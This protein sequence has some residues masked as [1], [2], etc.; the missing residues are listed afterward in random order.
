MHTSDLD[1]KLGFYSE[2][3]N[4]AVRRRRLIRYINLSL[5]ALGLPSVTKAEDEQFA[6]IARNMLDNYRAKTRLLADY[7]CPVDARIEEFLNGH[8]ADLDLGE[9]LRLP[10]LALTVDPHGMARELSL[11]VDGD[12]FKSPMVESYRVVNGV[13]HNPRND[14]R[15]TKGTFHVVEGGL[16]IPSGK[17]AVPRDAFVKMFRSAMN[18]PDDLSLIPFTANAQRPARA[19]VGLY[20]QPVVVPEVPGSCTEKRLEVR[21]F[22]PGGLVS[23]LDF[24]ESIFG[25]AGDPFLEAND[26]ARDVEHWTGHTGCVIL[27]P[28]LGTLTKRGLGLPQITDATDRQRAD[29]MCWQREDELYNDGLPFKVTCRT[30]EGVIVTLIADNYFGYCKKEVKTQISYSANLYGVAEEEHAG[31]ALVFPSFNI[32]DHYVGKAKATKDR[33][34]AQVRELYSDWVD[35]Q[36][37]GH[38]IDRRYPD[39]IFIPEDARASVTQ[40]TI[41]WT[42]NGRAQS[43]P[44][45]PEK[46]YM[47]PSGYKLRLERHP[48]APSWRLIGTIAEGTFC[49]KPC[50]V[51]G[52]GKSEISKSLHD[53]MLYGPIFV[54]DIE[55]DR[56]LIQEIF[57]KDYSTRWQPDSPE[58]SVY[59]TRPSRPPLS[60]ERSVGSLIKLLTPSTDYTDEYNEWLASIPNY[61][62]ALVFIIKRFY[63]SEWGKTG[64][65]D[66][67]TVDTVNGFP[68]HELKFEERKLVGSYLR[69]GFHAANS[70]RTFKLRQ[71]FSPSTKIQTEDDITASVVLPVNRIE[72]LSPY[73]VPSNPV[74]VKFAHNCEYRLFQRPDEA[75]HRGF[76]RQSEFDIAQS[77]N[78]LSNYQPIDRDQARRM[79]ERAIEFDAFTPPMKEA[80]KRFAATKPGEGPDYCV[81]S[82]DPRLVDGKPTKNPRYLQDRPDMVDPFPKHVAEMGMRLAR[83]I[84]PD[85]PVP[86]P[87]SSVLIGRRNNPP[88]RETGIRALAVYNPIHYQPVPELFMD[89]IASLTGKSPSTT[90][91]GSEGALTKGPFNALRPTADLNAALVSAILTD[92]PGFSTAAGHVGPNLRVDHDISLLVPELW[93]R[94]SPEE[95]RP[96]FL[97]EEGM[98][99][100]LDDFEYEGEL[101]HASRLGYRITRQFVRRFM[102]RIF[103]NPGKVFDESILRPETQDMAAYVDGIRN[104][105]EAQQRVAR[106]YLEDGTVDE[107]CPPLRALL[108][109]MGEGNYRGKTVHDEEIRDLFTRQSLLES[110]WYLQR[111]RTKQQRDI[112]LWERHVARS[113]GAVREAAKVRLNEVRNPDYMRRLVGTLGADPL[114]ADLAFED[115]PWSALYDAALET[116]E[117]GDL[118]QILAGLTEGLTEENLGHESIQRLR[119]N[120]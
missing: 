115:Q 53:Y 58:R 54:A 116:A 17:R 100:K 80:L 104:I 32:A 89:V 39:L 8:F 73:A 91:A 14:R 60:S 79:V 97:I 34:I 102:G 117:S 112:A 62:Y 111:L 38:C 50:T 101:I 57:D 48:A 109:I 106:S 118:K 23:N 45:M 64:W 83:L 11:P 99:E 72:N 108:Y 51:S 27:A 12:T 68:G 52:G 107:A 93:A 114:G 96:E 56:K 87:V 15:T 92:L 36:K 30:D 35:I 22:A 90:G 26:L 42:H 85:E 88:D 120:E 95:R 84:P 21:F 94:M 18:P 43:I 24:V 41:E 20:I 16:P 9:P 44:L 86:V 49:H 105:T 110:G 3:S 71:D 59:S 66:H 7:R 4:T 103:D 74:S 47:T 25:N 76:D 2:G 46:V 40:Q 70:W 13:L 19:M 55:N 78:F 63:R 31:G 77:T 1:T 65:M 75:I 119:M 69:V 6:A 67:F 61:I 10:S 5:D 37:E 28:Q 33:T 81:S 113:S 29:G 82:A 98:L